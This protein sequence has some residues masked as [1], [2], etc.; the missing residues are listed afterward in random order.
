MPRTPKQRPIDHAARPLGMTAPEL[1]AVLLHAARTAEAY[2]R[3]TG[4]PSRPA[5]L[6]RVAA[7]TGLSIS[8]VRMI[9]NR[10]KA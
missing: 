1:V 7:I 5:A 10:L 9:R 2:W 4:H 3:D 6:T 8:G